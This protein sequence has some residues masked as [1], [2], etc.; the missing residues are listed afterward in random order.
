MCLMAKKKQNKKFSLRNNLNSIVT[1][2]L[3]LLVMALIFSLYF[4]NKDLA[5]V[6]EHAGKRDLTY[7]ITEAMN[8]L[9]QEAPAVS[10]TNIQFIDEI[11]LQFSNVNSASIAYSYLPDDPENNEQQSATVTSIQLK[12]LAEIKLASQQTID[13][14]FSTLPGTQQCSR[15]FLLSFNN[16]ASMFY[17]NYT[18]VYEKTLDDGRTVFIRK[19]SDSLCQDSDELIAELFETLKTV[20]SY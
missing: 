8:N 16:E 13:D 7:F 9:T 10:Y 2:V 1:T 20:Q 4:V 5:N 6:K 3:F 15:P 17:E 14:M 19:T 12:N 18:T 11:K